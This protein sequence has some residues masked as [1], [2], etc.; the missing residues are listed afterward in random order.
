M[1]KSALRAIVPSVTRSFQKLRAGEPYQF[2]HWDDDVLYYRVSPRRKGGWNKKRVPVPEIRMALRRL[3]ESGTFSRSDFEQIC[4]I[5]SRD[6]PCGFCVVG[7]VLEILGVAKFSTHGQ[8][9]VLTD[10]QKADRM[11]M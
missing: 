2:D 7:R 9:F 3:R 4:P 5:A 10:S 6:G 11:L 8:G 1:L